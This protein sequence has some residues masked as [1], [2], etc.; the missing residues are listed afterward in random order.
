MMHQERI[1]AMREMLLAWYEKAKRD[2]PWRKTRDPYAI[3]LSEV[4]LQQTQVDRVRSKWEMWLQLFPTWQALARAKTADV[5]RAWSGLGYNR[6]ALMLQKLATT[7]EEQGTFPDEEEKMRELP[8][9][10][11]YTAAAVAAFA[12]RK[13]GSAPVDTNID[14]VLRRVFKFH[15]KDTK[16]IAALA[17]EVVPE[18]VAS[19]NHALMDLGASKCTARRPQCETCPLRTICASYPCEGDDIVKVKQK[20]FEGSDRMYRGRILR[21]LHKYGTL[22]RHEVGREIDLFDEERIDRLIKGLQK[23]AFI[24]VD[25]KKCIKI[26]EADQTS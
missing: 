21:A 12:F 7:V 26:K 8:G 20:K 10:G 24:S 3:V 14:R 25:E 23:E 16:A 18:D 6:R 13:K 22:R 2:L 1:T 17:K 15:G 19:W 9:I 11:P 4:M 5:L